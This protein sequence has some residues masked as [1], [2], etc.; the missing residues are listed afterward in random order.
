MRTVFKI[1]GGPANVPGVMRG[2][3]VMKKNSDMNQRS[4]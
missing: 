2:S 1:K 4:A 3:A